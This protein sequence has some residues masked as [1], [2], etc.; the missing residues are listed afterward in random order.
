MEVFNVSEYRRRLF[1]AVKDAE[2]FDSSNPSTVEMRM[3]CNEKAIDDMVM[4]LSEND[5]GVV[6]MD[7]TNDTFER[8]QHVLNKVSKC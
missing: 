8:R 3:K 5:T 4:F 1:G 6:I 2:W 7:S